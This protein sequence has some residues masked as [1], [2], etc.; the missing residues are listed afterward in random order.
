MWQEV[1]K[2]VWRLCTV[3]GPELD[4]E[5]AGSVNE[6]REVCGSLCGVFWDETV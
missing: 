6:Y 3:T 2:R 1:V 4:D 5:A